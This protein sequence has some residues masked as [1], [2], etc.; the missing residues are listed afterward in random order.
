EHLNT[1]FVAFAH[2]HVHLDRISGLHLRP[3]GHL[4]LFNHFNRA[5]GRLPSSVPST[6][7]GSPALPHQARRRSAAPAA[8]RASVPAPAASAISGFRRGGPTPA[9]PAPSSR[10]I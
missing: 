10:G 7:A 9:R 6:R 4:A 8:Y 2:L 3:F 1:L 5:H